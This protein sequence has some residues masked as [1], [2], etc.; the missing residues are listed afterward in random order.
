MDKIIDLHIHSKYS[1]GTWNL[2]KILQKAEEMK[3]HALSITDHDTI[4]QYKQ[5]AKLDYK[6][7]YTGQVIVGTE[8]NTVYDGVYFHMLAY[9]FDYKQLEKWMHEN[10]E[11]KE[12]DLKAEFDYIVN[13]CKQNNI[14]IDNVQ[15][16][17]KMGWPV[18]IIYPEI[19]KY[20][21]NRKYFD[22]EAWN[23]INIF[24]SSCVTNKDFPAFIDFSIH[25]PKADIVAK[26]VR[27]AGGRLF[28]AHPYRY[29][30]KNTISFL[31]K[32]RKDKIID[33]VEIYHSSHT[34]EE[35][36]TLKGNMRVKKDIIDDWNISKNSY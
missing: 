16:D 15:Y 12:P 36:S 23:D 11:V 26:E 18:E 7:I 1:D 8:F 9:G 6:K 19:K 33:G 32:L 29:S 10:Y 22:E 3:I 20:E 34:D 35:T 2:E 30:L 14:K 28:I 24:Y 17:K 4:A 5:L 21:E 25:Y 27:K 13:S 31:D